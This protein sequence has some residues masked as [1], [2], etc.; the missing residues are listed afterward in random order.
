MAQPRVHAVRNENMA[1]VVLRLNTV[2]KIRSRVY[3]RRTPHDLAHHDE[4][5]PN[6]DQ[7]PARRNARLPPG[8]ERRREQALNQRRRVRLRVAGAVGEQERADV[9]QRRVVRRRGPELEEVEQAQRAHEEGGSPE[10]GAGV[11]QQYGDDR[12][13]AERYPEAESVRRDGGERAVASGEEF[14]RYARRGR[15]R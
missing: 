2:I 13:A 1:L 15:W 11:R 6:P 7:N 3:H 14:V 9:R 10:G 8:E 12:G 5:E 4:H